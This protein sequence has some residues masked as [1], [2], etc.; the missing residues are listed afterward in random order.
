MLLHIGE[1]TDLAISISKQLETIFSGGV[2]SST[3][4]PADIENIGVTIALLPSSSRIH[5]YNLMDHA[6]VTL[7]LLVQ[8]ISA[9]Q[10]VKK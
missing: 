3:I 8:A 1:D 7:Q 5:S 9:I 4:I 2:I 6:R 10:Q